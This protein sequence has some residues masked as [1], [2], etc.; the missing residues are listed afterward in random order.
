LKGWGLEEDA[1]LLAAVDEA[2]LDGRDA[3]LLLNLLFDLGDLVVT[4]FG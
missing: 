3:L 1:H 4:N 2:L